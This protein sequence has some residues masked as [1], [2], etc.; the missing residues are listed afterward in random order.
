M[1]CLLA[2]A[3]CLGLCSL[4]VFAQENPV[5][6]LPSCVKSGAVSVFFNGK[7]ALKLAD[8]AAC[9]PGSFE[10]IPNIVIESQPMV[11]LTGCATGSTNV[12]AGGK[13]SNTTGDAP[14][15]Q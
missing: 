3:I 12:M 7:P 1:R 14:C 13:A 9:P 6:T 2:V 15:P 11:H 4:P 5:E 10:L 8:V